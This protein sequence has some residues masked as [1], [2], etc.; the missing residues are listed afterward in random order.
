MN[1]INLLK[2]L[3]PKK[4]ENDLTLIWGKDEVPKELQTARITA[5]PKE[6]K[7]IGNAKID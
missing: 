6:I 5:D 7:I 3:I 2:N 1:L 4:Y